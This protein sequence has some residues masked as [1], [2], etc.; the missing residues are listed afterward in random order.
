M[1]HAPCATSKIVKMLY[2]HIVSVKQVDRDV[3]V[4]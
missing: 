1:K 4:M 3:N 2:H